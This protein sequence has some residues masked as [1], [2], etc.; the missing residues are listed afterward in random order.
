MLKGKNLILSSQQNI[1]ISKNQLP[2]L[3]LKNTKLPFA[4]YTYKMSLAV[5]Y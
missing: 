5:N 1:Q 3:E 4:Y 2:C